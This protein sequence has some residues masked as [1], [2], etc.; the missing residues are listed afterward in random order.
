MCKVLFIITLCLYLVGCIDTQSIKERHEIARTIA[1]Q[2]N[3]KQ[4]KIVAGD[5]LL[6]TY[7]RGLKIS[8]KNLMVYVEGDGSAW[9]RK[10]RLSKN[11][12]PKNPLGLKLAA[13]DIANSILYI[14]RPCMYLEEE[15]LQDCPEKFW[16]SHRYSE[17]VIS[18]INQVIDLAV[19]A[20]STKSLTLVGYSGGGT[21][22]ALI[23]ARRN[24]V[25]S[26]IT[27]ASNLDHEFWTKLHDISPLTG[28][29]DPVEYV[30]TL[31]KIK[32]IHFVG[33]IDNIIPET[34]IKHYLSK[35]LFKDNIT[36]NVIK[37]FN[38]S[39]CWEDAWPELLSTTN[40]SL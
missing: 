29:L 11:P 16:S 19:G 5:F 37:D 3:L 7:H 31:S 17:Q 34:V 22:A 15:L 18:S 25:S 10:Y 8:D 21:I 26:F 23:A 6:T 27:I 14:A 1:S 33:A 36:I 13:K 35:M 28:S 38:H 4:E 9:D 30:D 2:T 39:C 32:Q 24:D 20:S 40:T 12:T